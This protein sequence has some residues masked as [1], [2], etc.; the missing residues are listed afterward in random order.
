MHLVFGK[1]S[2]TVT[3]LGRESGGS[4]E[5]MD[6]ANELDA[7]ALLAEYT[8]CLQYGMC[9]YLPPRPRFK[10]IQM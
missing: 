9:E 5:A 8:K 4:N 3:W 2:R 10:L 6:F 7:Q 1:A